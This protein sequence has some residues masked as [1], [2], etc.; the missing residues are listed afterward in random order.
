MAYL[1]PF[2]A[3][4]MDQQVHLRIMETSDIH[5]YVF[6]YD[7]YSDQPMNSMGLARTASLIADMRQQARNTILVDNGDFLQGSPMGDFAAMERGLPPGK[8]HP[9]VSAMNLLNYDAVTLGNHEFNFGLPYL[10]RALQDARFP[11]VS[12]N[13]VRR[14]GARPSQDETLFPPYVLLDRQVEDGLGNS[15]PLRIGVIGFLPPQV[16]KWDQQHLAGKVFARGIVEAAKDYLPQM[17]AEG[18]DIIL[19]LAHTGIAPSNST[20]VAENAALPL[21]RLPQVDALALG[22]V[23]LVFPS[24]HFAPNADLDPIHGTICGKPAVM[25][26]FHG[27]HLGLIDLLLRRTEAGWQVTCAQTEA[28]PIARRLPGG[29][30]EALCA[31]DAAMIEAVESDHMSTVRYMR[32]GVGTTSGPINSFFSLIGNCAAIHTI[33][34]AQSAYVASAL[35]GSALAKLP[36]LSS[37]AAFKSGGRGGP[38]NYTDIPPGKLKLRHIADL[39][40]FPNTIRA[41]LLTGAQLHEWLERSASMFRQVKP[42]WHRQRLIDPDFPGYLFDVVNGVTY[43]IDPTQ[44]PRYAPDGSLLSTKARRVRQL[45]HAGQPVAATDRFILATNNYRLSLVD[46]LSPPAFTEIVHEAPTPVRDILRSYIQSTRHLTPTAPQTWR[47]D[48]PPKTSVILDSCGK[49]LAHLDQ[50]SNLHAEP[51]G[52]TAEGFTRF[53]ISS[54]PEPPLKTRRAKAAQSVAP[55]DP[56]LYQQAEGREE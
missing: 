15:Y 8:T 31:S 19:A 10:T 3:R 40:P 52:K 25:P 11:V 7:Y 41:I 20:D 6:P 48:L 4:S 28:R 35:A 30:T 46:A 43:T 17:K 38:E 12:A 13:L 29:K 54:I 21:A 23:H 2:S 55:Q 33:N 47:L 36:L 34:Q 14:L 27:S 9:I 24:M 5:A 32:L 45:C 16:L 44:P 42:G 56:S 22:H 1:H 37:A 51:L 18:A 53:A 50:L 26:G 49:A 39:Y